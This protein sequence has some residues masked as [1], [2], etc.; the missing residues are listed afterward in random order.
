MWE[1]ASGSAYK[2]LGLAQHRRWQARELHR[3]SVGAESMD[4]QGCTLGIYWNWKLL[5]AIMLCDW[6]NNPGYIKE[7]ISMDQWYIQRMGD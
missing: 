4:N 1:S 2:G 7:L 5:H 6:T 3:L